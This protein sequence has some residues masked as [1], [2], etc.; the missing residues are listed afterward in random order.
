MKKLSILLFCAIIPYIGFA[1]SES[2]H[3]MFKGVPIDGTLKSF[4]QKLK[5]KNLMYIGTQDGVAILTGDFAGY[6]E[7]SIAAISLKEKDLVCKVGVI[8]PSFDNWNTLSNNYFAI[9]DMLT[10]KYGEPTDVVE[11]FQYSRLPNDDNLKMSLVK[12]D[13]CKFQSEFNTPNGDIQLMILCKDFKAY[14]T[15]IYFDGLNGEIAT[16]EAIDDL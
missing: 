13:R 2:E 12:T 16:S 5:E 9:K 4:V 8:F 6:K 14:V 11:E 15:L 7:C 10:Q 1:Q 3:L